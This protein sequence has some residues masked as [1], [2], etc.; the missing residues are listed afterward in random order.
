MVDGQQSVL[1]PVKPVV[2]LFPAAPSSKDQRVSL[3]PKSSNCGPVTNISVT[4]E[5]VRSSKVYPPPHLPEAEPKSAFWWDPRQ[6]TCVLKFEQHCPKWPMCTFL[7]I[8]A[9]DSSLTP[10]LFRCLYDSSELP[11]VQPPLW[12]VLHQLPFEAGLFLAER[13]DT[14]ILKLWDG[15]LTSGAIRVAPLAYS[16]WWRVQLALS[17]SPVKI[18]SPRRPTLWNPSFSLCL[19]V[20]LCT[21][22]PEKTS[23]VNLSVK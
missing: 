20:A 23:P 16:W 17:L 5:F 2:G 1:T 9:H 22:V 11:V 14:H 10:I 19:S 13:V 18:K 21:C 12:K 8:F 4:G 6:G 15:R 7:H 3:F